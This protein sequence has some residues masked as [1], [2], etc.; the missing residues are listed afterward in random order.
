MGVAFAGGGAGADAGGRAW[1]RMGAC[2]GCRQPG[3]VQR[4]ARNSAAF[5]GI[6]LGLKHAARIDAYTDDASARCGALARCC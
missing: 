1:G 5:W 2:G 3:V 6:W 4:G